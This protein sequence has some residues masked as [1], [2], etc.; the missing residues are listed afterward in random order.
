MLAEE[1]ACSL[2]QAE[3]INHGFSQNKTLLSCNKQILLKNTSNHRTKG[4]VLDCSSMN[5]RSVK[6]SLLLFAF[7]PSGEEMHWVL[8]GRCAHR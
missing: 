5:H 8:A 7:L 1:G 6:E 2:F 4:K 3:E